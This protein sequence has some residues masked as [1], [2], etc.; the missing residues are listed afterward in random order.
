MVD[1]GLFTT[2]QDLGRFGFESQ[3]VPT[4]GA[5]DEFAFRVANILVENDENA[6]CLEITLIGPTLE[7]LENTL[8]AV[9]GAEVQPFV[10]GFP[11]PCWSSFPVQKGDVITFSQVKSGC[12]AYLA[13]TGGFD[14]EFVMGSFSTYTKG[15]LGGIDGRKLQVGDILRC[16]KLQRGVKSKKVP[17]ELIP[18]Y[19]TNQEIRVILG[20]QDD[21]FTKEAI[22]V[23][24]NFVFQV[25]KDSDRMGY[26][27]E[28]P[29]IKAAR[30]H[31]IIT[32]AVVPGSVQVPGNG[33]PIVM[34]KDAQ[35]TGGYTK[36]ATVISTDL[37]KLAQLKPGDSLIFKSVDIETAHKI[38]VEN[39]RNIEQIKKSLKEVKYFTARIDDRYFDVYLEEL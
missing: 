6:P 11:R 2:I 4:S 13:V 22:E 27:L 30:K 29:E 39:E 10:N 18:T 35:T 15:K 24:L 12:R 7:V 28:G 23:F 19:S 9:T 36:I 14:G 16:R 3:G 5:M 8:V 31:D 17:D 20:P 32:D 37:S 34:M 33:K 21:Y 38:L 25:T 26:R 1:P